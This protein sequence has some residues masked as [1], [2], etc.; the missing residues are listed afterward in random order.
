MFSVKKIFLIFLPLAVVVGGVFYRQLPPE[1]AVVHPVRG[2][3]IEAVYATGAVEADPIIR[4]ATERAARLTSLMADEG[5]AVKKGQTL[6]LLDDSELQASLQEM[7]IRQKNAENNYS[8]LSKL[9]PRGSVSKEQLDQANTDAK[10]AQ[11]V[12]QQIQSQLSKLTILSPIDGEVIQRD[13]EIGEYLP[14]NQTLFYLR[15][16]NTPLRMTVDVDE[17]DIPKV[18][19]GQTVLI[20]ADAF[21]GKVMEGKVRDITFRGD[22]VTR[23][24]RVRVSLPA[25]SPLLIGMTAECNIII[26]KRDHVVLVPNSAVSNQI[27][28]LVRNGEAHKQD[29]KTGIRNGDKT[30]ITTGISEHD[31]IIVTPPEELNEGQKIRAVAL[32]TADNAS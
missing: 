31:E 27:I 30:E 12:T 11:A 8:R 25:D 17:E 6:A 13:G 9:F 4:I 16:N 10:A 19:T 21:A 24:Y 29:I 14:V 32:K 5:A 3:V 2:Q 1:V 26:A 15:Q 20:T 28:W 23:S 22:P 7:Q 18:K